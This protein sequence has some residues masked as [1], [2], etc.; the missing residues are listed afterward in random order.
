MPCRLWSVCGNRATSAG[1]RQIKAIAAAGT[2]SAAPTLRVDPARRSA[3]ARD[4]GDKSGPERNNGHAGFDD[5]NTRSYPRYSGRP[6][7]GRDVPRDP[8]LRWDPTTRRHCRHCYPRAIRPGRTVPPHY[9]YQCRSREGPAARKQAV[10]YDA[11]SLWFWR[12]SALRGR[13][14]APNRGV[15]NQAGPRSS[16]VTSFGDTTTIADWARPRQGRGPARGRFPC[17]DPQNWRIPN[18]RRRPCFTTTETAD[19]TLVKE[20]HKGC[21]NRRPHRLLWSD[22]TLVLVLR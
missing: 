11:S 14:S 16:G 22:V 17:P 12:S 2:A 19:P 1:S 9:R 10:R 15:Q 5:M 7:P 8:L 20:D 21:R 3:E 6:P 13:S 18:P 4:G